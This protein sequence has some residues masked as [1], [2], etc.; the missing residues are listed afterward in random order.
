[1]PGR[2]GAAGARRAGGELGAA[3]RCIG[4]VVGIER[5]GQIPDSAKRW[6]TRAWRD[7]SAPPR[8]GHPTGH[9]SAG[10]RLEPSGPRDDPAPVPQLARPLSNLPPHPNAGQRTRRRLSRG[11]G[12]GLPPLLAPHRRGEPLRGGVR[13]ADAAAG[14]VPGARP[15]DAPR[16]LRQRLL[17]PAAQDLA[18][19]DRRVTVV[20]VRREPLLVAQEESLR[21]SGASATTTQAWS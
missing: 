1:M 9:P 15:P 21:H 20:G 3:E 5:I 10:D 11:A 12:A 13:A 2:D 17:P 6:T 14:V 7:R 16:L 4:V 8:V 19:A 18:A